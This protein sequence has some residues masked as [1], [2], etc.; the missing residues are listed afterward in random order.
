VL[1]AVCAL[2]QC[3]DFMHVTVFVDI[4]AYS[5]VLTDQL[6][7]DGASMV[8]PQTTI[9]CG[10]LHELKYCLAN[11][12]TKLSSKLTKD[13][14]EGGCPLSATYKE[15]CAVHFD[16]LQHL[17]GEM[18]LLQDFLIALRSDEG[19][20]ADTLCALQ[21]C[22]QATQN[23]DERMVTEHLQRA[24]VE[25]QIELGN[26]VAPRHDAAR[27]A[28]VHECNRKHRARHVAALKRFDQ[29]TRQK[30]TNQHFQKPLYD[31]DKEKNQYKHQNRHVQAEGRKRTNTGHFAK[32]DN[33][34]NM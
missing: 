15:P 19:P 32:E 18:Q 31:F 4:G 1:Q 16:M 5:M 29:R 34:K 33:V 2:G 24:S 13:F 12:L 20:L 14:E 22:I 25:M 6:L 21:T 23:G 17:A 30:A 8:Q 10:L 7:A 11:Q 28:E 27:A 3:A 26:P 9:D